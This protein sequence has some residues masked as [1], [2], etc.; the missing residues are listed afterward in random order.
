MTGPAVLALF[1]H[2]QNRKEAPMSRKAWERS[3]ALVRTLPGTV[4]LQVIEICTGH[5]ILKPGALAEAGLPAEVVTYLTRT[6]SSGDSP[7][8]TLFV[9]DKPVRSLDGI[10]GLNALRHIAEAVGATYEE[11]LGRGR[12]ASNI[13]SALHGHFSRP[14]DSPDDRQ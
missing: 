3:A 10:W 13:K 2:N 8:Q 14:L 7:K 6:Y 11:A 1:I 12:E 9:D 5:N 4:I